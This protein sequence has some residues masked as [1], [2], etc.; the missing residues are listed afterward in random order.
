MIYILLEEKENTDVDQPK[1]HIEK[2]ENSYCFIPSR[3]FLNS[4]TNQN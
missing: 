4:S 3:L 2:N 1:Y